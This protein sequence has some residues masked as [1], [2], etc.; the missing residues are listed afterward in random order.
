MDVGEG[1]LSILPPHHTHARTHETF[2]HTSGISRRGPEQEEAEESE[3]HE[4]DL[5]PPPPLSP[6]LPLS[7]V[8]PREAD[9]DLVVVEEV[10][11]VKGVVQEG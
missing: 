2:A 8:S 4:D 1:L 9:M 10:V 3:E 7:F 5:E 6:L 11:V